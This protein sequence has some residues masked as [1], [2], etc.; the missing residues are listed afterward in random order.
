MPDLTRLRGDTI[1]T[2][3]PGGEKNPIYSRQEREQSKRQSQRQKREKSF[4]RPTDID[5]SP[6]EKRAFEE[7][8]QAVRKMSK[9]EQK[10]RLQDLGIANP[11]EA[12]QFGPRNVAGILVLAEMAE[13]PNILERLFGFV[14]GHMPEPKPLPPQPPIGGIRG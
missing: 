9:A 4:I 2:A 5:S 13:D 6:E 3:G 7:R 8:V 11:E 14:A 12:M 1:M 10:K